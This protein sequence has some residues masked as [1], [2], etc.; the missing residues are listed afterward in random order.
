MD[1]ATLSPLVPLGGGFFLLVYL[2]GT[3]INDRIVLRRQ[4]KANEAAWTKERDD[5]RAQCRRDIADAVNDLRQQLQFQRDRIS[6]LEL[7]NTRLR[8]K[9]D[10]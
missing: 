1:P 4:A 2:I 8:R 6:E 10:V 9:D 5:L 3:L 7:E